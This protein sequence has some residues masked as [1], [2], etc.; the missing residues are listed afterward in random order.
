MEGIGSFLSSISSIVQRSKIP[1]FNY[2][3]GDSVDEFDGKSIWSLYSGIKNDNKEPVSIFV[4]KKNNNQ[5][6]LEL[7][8]N[9]LKR[10]KTLR[11]PDF[12]Q[13]F[14]SA[15]TSEAIYIAT[16]KVDPLSNT[17]LN[18]ENLMSVLW[19]LFKICRGLKFI[20]EDCNLVH[21]NVQQSSIFV[22]KS[23]EWKLFGFELVDSINEQKPKFMSTNT[24]GKKYSDIVTPEMKN[25]G[26]ISINK[27][28]IGITDSFQFGLLLSLL[29]KFNTF[30][31]DIQTRDKISRY[32][33]RLNNNNPKVRI[34]IKKFLAES[35]QKGGIFDTSFIR[36][37]IFIEEISTK[38][39]SQVKEILDDINQNI[40][41]YP[42]NTLKYKILPELIK[43]IN[44][45]GNPQALPTVISIGKMLSQDDFGTLVLPAITKLFSSNDR[46]IRYTLLKHLGDYINELTNDIVLKTIYPNYVSG[47]Q[48]SAPAIREE[49]AKASLLFVELLPSNTV[50]NELIRSVSRL[51]SDPEPG[52][53]ANCLICIG[54]LSKHLNTTSVKQTVIPALLTSLRDPF[55]PS[56]S[57]CL[58]AISVCSSLM[59][60]TD[61][62]RKFLPIVSQLLIDPE[63]QVRDSSK[64]TVQSLLQKIDDYVKTMPETAIKPKNTTEKSS[65]PAG[66]SDNTS[67]TTVSKAGWAISS[68]TSGLSGVLSYTTSLP[69]VDKS[70]DINTPEHGPINANASQPQT[71]ISTSRVYSEQQVVNK[72]SPQNVTSAKNTSNSD[73][74]GFTDSNLDDGWDMDKDIEV[75]TGIS[76]L[77]FNENDPFD[78]VNKPK[79]KKTN[80]LGLKSVSKTKA[81]NSDNWGNSLPSTKSPEG[82]PKHSNFGENV[83][84]RTAKNSNLGKTAFADE[85][86]D[87]FLGWDE[88]PSTWSFSASDDIQNKREMKSVVPL[89]KTTKLGQKSTKGTQKPKNKLGAVKITP[90][91]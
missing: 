71:S 18:S 81:V 45:G 5:I 75:D 78:F 13:F 55:P 30:D 19:G 8:Q 50:N 83:Q 39:T 15:E 29:N 6:E 86:D 63:K 48:D 26:S 20:N 73:T 69:N 10:I 47:F 27:F 37:N 70:K 17:L 91:N 44:F 72:G 42:Q 25:S 43:L 24:L 3:I 68:L 32:S 57:A 28:D 79:T 40:H 89:Q 67:Q 1:N 61:I 77:S 16:E 51:V 11:H 80:L 66:N 76:N 52:I 21:G 33:Q 12:L 46:L 60:P 58:K 2:T 38:D 22:S 34:S 64:S 85:E 4:Y 54:K 62:T 31:N 9:G 35:T 36:F 88:D 7:A 82:S 49:T 14:D 74:F 41:V 87:D 53:R 23:N 84:N 59:D 65:E 56:R 90:R